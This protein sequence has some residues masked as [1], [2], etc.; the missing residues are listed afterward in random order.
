VV[1]TSVAEAQGLEFDVVVV[2]DASSTAYPDTPTARR[3]LYVA[4]TRAVDWL[5][6]TTV[7]SWSPMLF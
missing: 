2:P 5:W 3:A 4:M 6:L 7:G 1:V